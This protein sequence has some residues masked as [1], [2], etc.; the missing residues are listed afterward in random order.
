MESTQFGEYSNM[1]LAELPIK[2]DCENTQA[3]R[4]N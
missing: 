3:N 4:L 2:I 1:S